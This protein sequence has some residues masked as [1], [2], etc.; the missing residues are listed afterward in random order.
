MIN[1]PQTDF[2]LPGRTATECD[3]ETSFIREKVTPQRRENF[4][5]YIDQATQHLKYRFSPVPVAL[6]QARWQR[7]KTA[8]EAA[9][10]LMLSA[11]YQQEVSQ[12]PWLLPRKPASLN[13]FCGSVDFLLGEYDEKIIEVNP[14]PPGFIGYLELIDQ[15]RVAAYGDEPTPSNK[16]FE[17]AFANWVSA[18]GQD[19]NVLI[20]VNHTAASGAFVPHYRYIESILQRHGLNAQ[21]VFANELNATHVNDNGILWQQNRFSRVFNLVIPKIMERTPAEFT[22]Y[23]RL[24]HQHPGLIFPNPFCWRTGNKSILCKFP[25]I[26]QQTFCLDKSQ[27]KALKQAAL[28]TFPLENFDSPQA[29]LEQFG[30][31]EQIILKPVDDYNRGGL[32]IHPTIEQLQQLM[33]ESSS[34]YIV[35]QYYPHPITLSMTPDNRVIKQQ[36]TTRVGYLNGK[37]FGVRGA[38]W[39]RPGISSDITSFVVI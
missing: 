32:F 23:I 35:Q 1:Y 7:L 38:S 17:Q 25:E 8:T 29:V 5:L 6:E 15:A 10:S 3:W 33:Q 2:S 12:Q 31:T 18:N 13:D 20:A 36:F 34:P 27:Q 21:M 37:V 19:Q 11:D 14:I 39:H 9:I 4:Q 26:K 28:D 30:G 16:G 22:D 24:Y